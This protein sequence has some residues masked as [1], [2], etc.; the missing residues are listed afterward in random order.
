[1]SNQTTCAHCG[2]TFDGG[3]AIIGQPNARMESLL[4]KLGSHM[5]KKHPQYA[6]G[7]QINGAAFMGWMFLRNFKSTD[8]ELNLH[9]DQLRWQ[10]H[11]QTLSARFSDES[12]K[13]QCGKLAERFMDEALDIPVTSAEQFRVIAAE[14]LLEVFTGM[15]NDLEEPNKYAVP[16]VPQVVA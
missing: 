14:I 10:I 11:Q 5:N 12:L 4:M 1:M 6:Q 2:E 7:L 15:R 13:E 8:E 16:E 9:R 3:V